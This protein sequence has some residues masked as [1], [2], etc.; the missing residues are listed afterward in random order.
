M[1]SAVG[2]D[3]NTTAETEGKSAK[4]ESFSE[5]IINEGKSRFSSPEE[6]I[7]S[8][9][10][11]SNNRPQLAPSE[12]FTDESVRQYY[13]HTYGFDV[14]QL[15]PDYPRW[16]TNKPS[17]AEIQ[18]YKLRITEWIE[19]NKAFTEFLENRKKELEIK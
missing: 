14:F 13:I 4:Q 7:V 9:R 10:W 3:I 2:Q 11:Y 1:F 17:L 15:F 18:E 16:T 5:S 8:H 12:M 19:K 6:G